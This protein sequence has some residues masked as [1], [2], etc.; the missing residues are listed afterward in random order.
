VPRA[1]V[2]VA[3]VLA[4][5]IAQYWP[6]NAFGLIASRLYIA[7]CAAAIG[8]PVIAGLLYDRTQGYGGAVLIAAGVNVLGAFLAIGLPARAC[9]TAPT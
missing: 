1:L 8:L 9:A 7:W 4:A 6:K 5:A 2:D 3:A